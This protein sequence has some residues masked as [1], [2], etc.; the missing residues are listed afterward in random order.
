VH[1]A[2][3]SSDRAHR[4]RQSPRP[5]DDAAAEYC[6]YKVLCH[7]RSARSL[8]HPRHRQ[9][10][11]HCASVGSCSA[12]WS[13][14]RHVQL[15]R[16]HWKEQCQGPAV[17]RLTQALLATLDRLTSRRSAFGLCVSL[18]AQDLCKAAHL[19][20]LH[21]DNLLVPRY[22]RVFLHW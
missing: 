17:L 6:G 3:D 13:P 20:L 21:H 9:D 10:Q 19:H 16:P 18:P 7:Y 15:E 12:L 11:R 1:A 5:S 2:D 22:Q 8:L 4:H 14:G